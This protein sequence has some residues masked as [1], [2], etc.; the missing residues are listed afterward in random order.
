LRARERA[1]HSAYER[2]LLDGLSARG[3][4]LQ[5]RL[6]ARIAVACAD[7]AI[8]RWFCDD[9]PTKPGLALKIRETFAELG[10]FS[11]WTARPRPADT[12]GPAPPAGPP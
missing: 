5:A 8:G 7:E 9:N 2:V 12:A 3:L 10:L 11:T 6:L 1:K 4:D